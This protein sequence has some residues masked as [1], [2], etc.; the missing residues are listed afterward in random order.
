VEGNYTITITGQYD[1][2][3]FL[4][5]NNDDD[6]DRLKLLEVLDFGDMTFGNEGYWF[7][8]CD[9]AVITATVGPD[10]TGITTYAN[11]FAFMDE[12]A[13]NAN[14]M[15]NWDTSDVTNMRTL[16]ENNYILNQD[17]SN[18]YVYFSLFV[19]FCQAFVLICYRY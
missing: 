2:W 14:W 4:P 6:T 9:N 17:L 8:G 7:N 15:V 11:G 5:S 10:M 13:F 19:L 18:W 12:S 3:A 1:G 16:F